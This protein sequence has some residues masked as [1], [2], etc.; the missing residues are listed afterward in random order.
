VNLLGANAL[1]DAK[2]HNNMASTVLALR[3][4][5]N[6]AI[7]VW[8]SNREEKRKVQVLGVMFAGWKRGGRRGL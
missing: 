1:A 5:N 7:V 2:I 4:G 3:V 8:K 6:A